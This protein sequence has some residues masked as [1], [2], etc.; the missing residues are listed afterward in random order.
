MHVPVL[1]IVGWLGSAL[2]VVSLA[3][4]RVVRFRALNLVACVV[5]VAYNAVLGVWPMA[6]VNLVLTGINAWV[7]AGLLR[8]RHDARTYEAVPVGVGE[9]FLARLLARHE[10]DIR[11]IDPGLPADLLEGAD[12]AFVVTTGDDVVGVVLSAA[13]D[14]PDEQRVLLD[15]VLPPYRDLTPGEFVYRPDGPFAALGT[16]RVVVERPVPAAE[17]YLAAVGF[18]PE[19]DRRVLDL[20]AG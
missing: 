5:L 15:H 9:P 6:A 19:G 18:R 2:L 8:R 10:A 13:G 11:A 4:T 1:E 17:R 12:H 14:R 7:L 16:R 20:A 3:Q